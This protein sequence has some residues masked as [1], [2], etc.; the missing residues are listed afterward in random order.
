MAEAGRGDGKV[1]PPEFLAT[2]PADETRIR[3]IEKLL[4]EELSYYKAR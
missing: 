4:P 3:Q 1:K 2:H